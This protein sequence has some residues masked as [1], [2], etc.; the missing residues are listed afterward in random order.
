MSA[1]N[2]GAVRRESDFYETPREAIEKLIINY[3]FTIGDE[4]FLEPCAGNGAIVRALRE[5]YAS[6]ININAIEIREEERSNLIKSGADQISIANF[7][8]IPALNYDPD[9]IITNPP[10]S[11]A[12]EIIEHCFKIAPESEIIM[13]LRLAFLES[14]KESH[15]GTSTR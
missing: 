11:I 12:Q 4:Y 10:F 9:I 3:H 6:S 13:L 1:T 5:R 15:S 2:R 8:E 14:K 7:L